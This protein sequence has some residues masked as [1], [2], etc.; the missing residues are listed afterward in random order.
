MKVLVTGANGQLGCDLMTELRRRGHKATGTDLGETGAGPYIRLDITDERAVRDAVLSLRPDAVIHCAAWTA[1]DAAEDAENRERVWKINVD[2]TRYLAEACGAA[3]SKMVYLSTDYVF[4]GS[5]DAPWT[6][7][8]GNFAPLNYYGHTKLEGERAVA[9]ATPRHFIV[10]TSWVFGL[11][12]GNFVKTMLKLAET[13][14]EVRVVND[15][16]GSPTYT[17]DLARLLADMCETERYGIYH[18]SNEGPYVS[19]CEF[20][21]EIF[22]QA[23]RNVRVLPVSTAEYGFSKAKR[24][25]NSRLDKSKL[26]RCGFALLPPWQEALGRYLRLLAAQDGVN[27]P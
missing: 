22:A 14:N 4:D 21:R 8:C 24:P 17:P 12:G 10:R 11:H 23:G 25:C 3:G 18:A 26:S 6:P 7:E 2:G 1:V 15:Q 19:W 13:R 27:A 16:I 5:G 20:A 9:A